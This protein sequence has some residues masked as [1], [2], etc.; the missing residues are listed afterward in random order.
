MLKFLIP[1]CYLLVLLLFLSMGSF[2]QDTSINLS[3]GLSGYGVSVK[4][5]KSGSVYYIAGEY[6]ANNTSELVLSKLTKNGEVV[7]QKNIQNGTDLLVEYM[8]MD[9]LENLF[10][11]GQSYDTILKKNIAFVLKLDT[12]GNTL[13]DRRA[14]INNRTSTLE[15]LA[16]N[17]RGEIIG[18]GAIVNNGSNNIFTLILNA[19]G[20]IQNY[21]EQDLGKN[22]IGHSVVAEN[23]KITIA[24]DAQ[25]AFDE[26]YDA[27][28]FQLDYEGNV[29]WEYRAD[30][31]NNLGTQHLRKVNDDYIIIGEGN[32][33]SV[34]KFNVYFLKLSNNGQYLNEVYFEAIG[35]AAGFSFTVNKDSIWLTGYITNDTVQGVMFGKIDLAFNELKAN[36]IVNESFVGYDI[37]ADINSGFWIAANASNAPYLMKF[38]PN[39]F[40]YL[41]TKQRYN[42]VK[43]VKAEDCIN[44]SIFGEQIYIKSDESIESVMICDINGRILYQ[45]SAFNADNIAIDASKWSSSLTLIQIRTQKCNK[46]VRFIVF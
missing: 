26:E 30:A 25:E 33:G 3:R 28:I 46:T 15:H 16:S 17:S 23:D 6:L 41:L 36:L 32:I 39:K 18:V 42:T 11:C 38:F 10:I 24:A 8:L 19:D 13:W 14:N 7:F 31:D 21:Y 35:R 20:S 5:A 29:L 37:I 4:Q 22:D 40:Q 1:N 34:E 45:K 27:Y 9:S 12:N 2:A 43:G 44:I